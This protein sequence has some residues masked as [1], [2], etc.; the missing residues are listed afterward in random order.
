MEH[1]GTKYLIS[2]SKSSHPRGYD[3]TVNGRQVTDPEE[4]YPVG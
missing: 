1:A 3:L 4:G 2:V